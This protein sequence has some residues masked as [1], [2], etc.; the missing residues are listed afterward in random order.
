MAYS[1]LRTIDADCERDIAHPDWRIFCQSGALFLLS[2]RSINAASPDDHP[3]RDQVGQ[4]RKSSFARIQSSQVQRGKKG[5]KEK[6]GK[7][8]SALSVPQIAVYV[9]RGVGY[10]NLLTD[11]RRRRGYRLTGF[12][13]IGRNVRLT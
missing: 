13:E 2:L 11:S 5:W 12:R 6:K 8:E 7:E 4:L 9:S 3:V 1:N 10:G